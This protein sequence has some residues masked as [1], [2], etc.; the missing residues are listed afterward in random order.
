MS[1]ALLYGHNFEHDLKLSR[2]ISNVKKNIVF[3]AEQNT[4]IIGYSYAW[5]YHQAAV[6]GLFEERSEAEEL[7]SVLANGCKTL[8]ASY[9]PG[10]HSFTE[11]RDVN[12]IAK[13]D[14]ENIIKKHS[15]G[16]ME[17]FYPDDDGKYELD[18]DLVEYLLSYP[19]TYFTV[20]ANKKMV[21]DIK[22]AVNRKMKEEA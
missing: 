12:S 8:P 13:L 14:Y 18:V 2:E 16:L 15:E 1:L 19:A 3:V 9:L 11:W 4:V 7:S 21:A 6:L 10:G 22:N 5:Q 20:W 17:D